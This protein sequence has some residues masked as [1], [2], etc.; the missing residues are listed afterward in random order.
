M[1][2][3]KYKVRDKSGRAITGSMT[4]ANQKE[5]IDNLRKMGYT[6]INVEEKKEASSGLNLL[7]FNRVKDEDRILFT[8][9]MYAL[10][11]AGVSLLPSLEAIGG[12][13]KSNVLRQAVDSMKVEIEAGAS[14]SESLAKHPKIFSPLYVSMIKAGETAGLLDQVMGRLAEFGE[15]ELDLKYQVK[16]ATRY[17][18]IAFLSLI[19]VF[20][21]LVIFVIPRFAELFSR[22]NVQLPL[23][24][25]ILIG[26]Y[27]VISN[28]W[29]LLIIGVVVSII[30]FMK[31]INT[32]VGRRLWDTFKLKVPVIGP[33]FFKLFMSRFSKTMS[34]LITSGINMLATL[35][36]VAGTIGNVVIAK[37]VWFIKEGVNEG[38]G[39][40]EPMKTSK[41]FSPIVIQM[42]SIGEEAGKLDELL[43][44]V[45]EY[46]DQ[47]LDYAM[48]N[49]TTMIEPMLIFALG[50]MVLFVGLGVFL[51]LWNMI[52]MFQS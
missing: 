2:N 20:F 14:L 18:I 7:F 13:T 39:L 10:I 47:Q 38:K 26:I 19:A 6:P 46:Y 5:A 4:Q 8:R 37:A 15:R 11:R 9:Q 1:P 16:A 49:L 33:L 50:F 34:I 24:T 32:S 52:N 51:P 48:K 40:A 22:Y 17:P 3:F 43:M 42:V 29:H 21:G 35:D 28:Y 30:L 45:S 41:L 31:F 23:P 36:L 44:N 25:R 12:Q 27:S